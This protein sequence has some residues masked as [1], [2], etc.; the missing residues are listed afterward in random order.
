MPVPAA[1]LVHLTRQLVTF[2]NSGRLSDMWG[3]LST[4]AIVNGLR[5]VDAR[6]QTSLAWVCCVLQLALLSTKMN[7]V[8]ACAASASWN[9]N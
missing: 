6:V 9:A 4:D 3:M 2:Q 7:Y 8:Y 1:Q 5:G